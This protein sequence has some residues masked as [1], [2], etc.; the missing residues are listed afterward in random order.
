[1]FF[2]DID[3]SEN[4]TSPSENNEVSIVAKNRRFSAVSDARRVD[5]E[6]LPALA[7]KDEPTFAT[8]F[9]WEVCGKVTTFVRTERR[10]A[11]RRNTQIHS[12]ICIRVQRRRV[13]GPGG[14]YDFA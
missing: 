9:R 4:P 1:M 8:R 7:V 14:F 12:H 6:A 13:R 10:I 2:N 3:V 5:L 11:E